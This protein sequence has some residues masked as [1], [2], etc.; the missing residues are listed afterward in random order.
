M[1]NLLKSEGPQLYI[2]NMNNKHLAK[3]SFLQQEVKQLQEYVGDLKYML[4]LNKEA[5]RIL[6]N[7]K[8]SNKNENDKTESNNSTNNFSN[9]LNNNFA[10]QLFEENN[11]LTQNIEILIKERNIAQSKVKKKL[12]LKF[13]NL[14]S[15]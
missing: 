12:N 2:D 7:T 6:L 4:K 15:C 14:F 10:E 3:I 1:E 8:S 13:I 11:R 5:M 9:A